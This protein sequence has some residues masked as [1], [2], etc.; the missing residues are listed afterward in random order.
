MKRN[1]KDIK[2]HLSFDPGNKSVC[3][4]CGRAYDEV[5][6]AAGPAFYDDASICFECIEE[7]LSNG[8]ERIITPSGSRFIDLQRA[9]YLRSIIDNLSYFI[10][11]NPAL[12]PHI[13]GF[14]VGLTAKAK[15]TDIKKK[16]DDPN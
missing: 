15:N 12:L 14:L 8:A 11:T 16:T 2:L 4:F 5:T 7:I 13:A 6:M 9:N 10:S 1:A 3:S